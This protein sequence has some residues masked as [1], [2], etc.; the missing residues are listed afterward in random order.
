MS[1]FRMALANIEFEATPE[2]S[3]TLAEHPDG[4]RA[5]RILPPARNRAS[6]RPPCLPTR[7]ARLPTKLFQRSEFRPHTLSSPSFMRNTLRP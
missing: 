6:R 1:T 5:L 3:L 2:E 7:L 4:V